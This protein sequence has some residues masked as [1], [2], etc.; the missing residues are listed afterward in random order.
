MAMLVK[1][2]IFKFIFG[3]FGERESGILKTPIFLD[4]SNRCFKQGGYDDLFR[5]QLWCE[6]P[7][8]LE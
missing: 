2:S 6:K 1:S 4:S 7:L 3:P 8:D 5:L